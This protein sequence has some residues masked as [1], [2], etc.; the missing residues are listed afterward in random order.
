M[1]SQCAAMRGA[2]EFVARGVLGGYVAYKLSRIDK[3][4]AFTS[5]VRVPIEM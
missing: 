3:S 4:T 1:V 2:L 5:L